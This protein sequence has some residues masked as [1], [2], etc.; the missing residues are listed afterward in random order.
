MPRPATPECPSARI[1]MTRKSML[2]TFIRATSMLASFSW[3][4]WN[5]PI[6]WPHSVSGLG[7]V[8]AQSKAFS[9]TPSA[10]EATLIRSAAKLDRALSRP[11]PEALSSG[12]PSSRSRPNRTLLK[13]SSP[14][15]SCECPSC[16]MA[17]TERS[18]PSRGRGQRSG[19]CGLACRRWWSPSSNLAHHDDVGVGTVGDE[20]LLA[21]EDV[22]VDRH[23]PRRTSSCR[24]ASELES[25][26]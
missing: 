19:P 24:N 6:S 4:S 9:I 5:W 13:N 10:I 8:D 22:V 23:G 7:I 14:V 12:S 11:S 3:M 16:G 18:L 17:L 2:R 1:S 21:I 15:Q 26:W 25:G 20:C